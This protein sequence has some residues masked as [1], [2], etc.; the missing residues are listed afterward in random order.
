MKHFVDGDQL[1]ITKDNFVNLQE[2]SAVFYPLTS[3]TAQTVIKDGV[4]GLPLA[5]LARIRSYLDHPV[6]HRGYDGYAGL[7]A[8]MAAHNLLEP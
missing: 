5:T 4:W 3:D 1:V 6:P 8:W 2:S 7:D